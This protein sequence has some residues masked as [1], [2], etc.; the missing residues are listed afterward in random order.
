[1]K[2]MC[3]VCLNDYEHTD[4]CFLGESAT[5]NDCYDSIWNTK[6]QRFIE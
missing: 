2:H 4:E 5:C 1:M 3:N 6:Y